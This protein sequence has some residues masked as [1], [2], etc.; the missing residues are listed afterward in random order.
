VAE[1]EKQEAIMKSEGEKMKRINEAEGRAKE[2]MLVAQATAKGIQLI[3]EAIEAPG[4]DRAVNLRIAEQYIKEFGNLA[5]KN[6]T[7]IIPQT[8][9]DISGLIATATSVIAKTGEGAE[10]SSE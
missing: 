3:A 5:K 6:N 4:G 10:R 2:I 1:G 8:M 9:T 7:M